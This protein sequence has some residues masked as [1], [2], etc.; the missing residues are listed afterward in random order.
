MEQEIIKLSYP[1]LK[2]NLTFQEVL[3][4]RRSRRRFKD[5]SLSEKIISMLLYSTYGIT[6]KVNDL[7]ASPSA[8]ATYPADIYLVAGKVEGIKSGIYLYLYKNHSL[9]L[10]KPGDFRQDLAQAALSQEFIAQAPAS[11]VIAVEYQRTTYRY[12]KRGIMY[13]HI[14][15]GHIAENLYLQAE[16]LGIGTV[17]VG[18]FYEKEVSNILSLSQGITP[19]YILPFGYYY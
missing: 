8:G 10:V 2:S 6:D 3:V 17:G 14:E 12:G 15:V 13:V 1:D 5:K 16:S 19:C 7:R 9:K 11:I 18:A 4:N